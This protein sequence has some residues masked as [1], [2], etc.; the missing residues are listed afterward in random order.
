MRKINKVLTIILLIAILLI[1]VN[2]VFA[3]DPEAVTNTI[4]TI[5]NQ[6]NTTKVNTDSIA[7]TVGTIIAY[8]RNAAIIIGI[9]LI[10]IIG[11]R[12]MTGSVEEKVDYKKSFIPLIVGIIVV[13]AA[14]SIASFLFGLFTQS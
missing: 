13:M 1:T 2:N 8:L 10:V 4:D 14:T 5:K 3:M 11:I 6:A 12:Y 7:K 9:V